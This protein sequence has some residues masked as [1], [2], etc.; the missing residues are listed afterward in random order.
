MGGLEGAF[1]SSAAAKA[2]RKIRDQIKKAKDQLNAGLTKIEPFRQ[3]A[4]DLIGEFDAADPAAALNQL[5]AFSGALG[6]QA[7]KEAFQQFEES[8]G[9]AFLRERGIRGINRQLAA[10]GNLGSGSRLEALTQFSQ[11]LAKQ[12]L[13]RQ[14]GLLSGIEL[15][16]QNLLSQRV[17]REDI[18]AGDILTNQR[19]KA[20][21]EAGIAI[22]LGQLAQQRQQA[23]GQII[24]GA[25]G[26][27]VSL[28]AFAAGGPAGVALTGGV[29]G[30][31]TGGGQTVGGGGSQQFLGP[32]SLG[33]QEMR[34]K[35]G[36]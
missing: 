9:V 36:G 28:A 11:N 25:I 12:D 5:R 34:R 6:P 31:Q 20:Q 32:I 29:G 24:T 1:D 23:K 21:F 22:P 35:T 13:Q 17:G 7:Q 8:P 3:A 18:E 19:I 27:V 26:D 16:E 15:R 33:T 14:L 10:G 30:G 2:G 4:R